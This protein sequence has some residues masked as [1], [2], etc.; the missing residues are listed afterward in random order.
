[1][2]A[3]YLDHGVGSFVGGGG[4]HQ[5]RASPSQTAG[6]GGGDSSFVGG[7]GDGDFFYL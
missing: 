1:M 2:A 7:S 5:K 4:L 3:H 6:R